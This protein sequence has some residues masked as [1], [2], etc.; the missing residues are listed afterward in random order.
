[1]ELG[2][3]VRVRIRVRAPARART[4][5]KVRVRVRVRVKARACT[6]YSLTACFSGRCV[7]VMAPLLL[8]PCSSS[9]LE[10]STRT[11]RVAKTVTDTHPSR[12]AAAV[13]LL[14]GAASSTGVSAKRNSWMS[15]RQR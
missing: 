9:L 13:L 2:P 7:A 6:P 1:M 8:W 10:S 3:V 5:V 4:R 15:R 12:C 14:G 11:R